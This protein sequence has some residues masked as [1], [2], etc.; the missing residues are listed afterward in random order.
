MN[1][2]P[3][4]RAIETFG[5]Q[6]SKLIAPCRQRHEHYGRNHFFQI[7]SLPLKVEN[8]KFKDGHLKY[9]LLTLIKWLLPWEKLAQKGSPLVL[10]KSTRTP[11]LL[12]RMRGKDCMR[13][14]ND[15]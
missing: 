9:S 8:T 5:G 14:P 11:T 6:L 7:K 2:P 13:I 10:M 15:S 3:Q 4:R 1:P 12:R